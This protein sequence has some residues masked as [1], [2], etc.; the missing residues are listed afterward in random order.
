MTPTKQ[1]MINRAREQHGHITP[2]SGKTW[3]ECFQLHGHGVL[4]FYFNDI[5]GNTHVV[6]EGERT[7]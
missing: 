4:M 6:T 5:T 3:E 7:F 1:A 2:C